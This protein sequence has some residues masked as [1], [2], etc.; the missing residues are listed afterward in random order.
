[1]QNVA[2]NDSFSKIFSKELAI[3]HDTEGLP[4]NVK[5]QTINYYKRSKLLEIKMKSDKLI[6]AQ[7]LADIEDR[8]AGYFNIDSVEVKV[9]YIISESIEALLNS[10]W[11]SIVFS[12]CR[13]LATS[14]GL[15]SGCKWS[16]SERKLT[17]YLKTKGADI[18]KAQG[19]AKH[20]ET[21]IEEAFSTRIK[22]EFIDCI[23]DEN[24]KKKY[25]EKKKTEEQKVLNNIIIMSADNKSNSI[26]KN[27]TGSNQASVADKNETQSSIIFGKDFNDSLLKMKEINQDSGKVSIG[28]D[29][30]KVEFRE[31]RGE[32]FICTFDITDNTNSLTVKFFVKKD[33]I[34]GVKNRIKEG[35]TVKVRGEAQ[36]DKFSRDVA[37]MASDIVLMGKKQKRMDTAKVKRVE[38]HLHTQMSAMDGVTSVEALVKRASEWGHKAIAI[39]DHGVIQA[40]PGASAMAGKSNIKIIYGVECYLVDDTADEN[41]DY[42]K[43]HAYH[44]II[45][46]Q[47]NKGLKNLYKLI[48]K[49]HL[50][51]YYKKPRMFKSMIL[52]YRE[53]LILGTA[54]E[55]GELYNAV[56]DNKSEEE[57]NRIVSFYDYLEIQPLG[58]NQFLVENGRVKNR[59][60]L[61]KINMEIVKLGEKLQKPVVAT[62]DV[63]FLD[64]EDEVY[65]R[66]LMA[67]QGY[68]DADK[69]APLYLRT[70]DEMLAE[71]EYLG[72]EKAYE[73]V[74]SNPNKINDMLETIAPVP[75]GTFP[76]QIEGA[77]YEIKEL[78]INH[79]KEK[80]GDPLPEIVEDRLEKEL[81]SIIKN[82]FSVMYLIAIKLVRKSLSDGYLVGSRGSVGSSF[83]AYLTGITEVNPLHAHYVCNKCKYSE[84][85]TDG[86]IDCGYDL[87]GKSCPQCGENL[88]RDG[89][90]I[91]FETFLGFNGDKEPDIDLNFS[92]Q[93][94]PTA[95]KFVE[96]LFGEGHVFRAGTIAS[97]AE[98]TAYGFAK[99][100]LDE[101]GIVT[102]TAELNRLIK[103][104]TGI[105]RTTGQHPGGVM[106]IPQD[107]EIYDFTPIQHPAD[108]TGSNTITTHFDYNFLHGSILKLD[109]LGHDDP[110]TIRMLEDLTGIDARTIPIGDPETMKLFSSTSSLGVTP[111]DVN[112]EV[113]TLGIPEF[114]TRFV[115]QMLV[116]TRPKTMSELIRISGLSHGTDVWINNAQDLIKANIASLSEVIC[117]RDD[118]MLYLLY[119]GLP[120]ITSFKIMED[121]RKGKGLKPEYEDIMKANNVPAWYIDSCKKI[122]YMFPKAHAAAYVMMAFRIAWFKVNYPV[123]FYTTYFTVKADEFDAEV[124]TQNHDIIK[125]KIMELED[126]GN[127]VTQK[128]KS[129]LTLLEVVNEMYSR[130]INF[131]PV[132]LYK[133]EAK[134]FTIDG[135]SIRPPLNGLPGLGITAAQNIVEARKEEKFSSIE[136]LRI[137]AKVSKTVIDILKQHGCLDDLPESSQISLF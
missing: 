35:I 96:E 43:A 57:I 5:V 105:K 117:T 98:K 53:G 130:G 58:N 97:V 107:K 47:N 106:I 9:K 103:G 113:G 65:R 80:Y 79:A 1:V 125:E 115:R 124:M 133:S 92:G 2:L 81:E 86:S 89:Y 20:M 67:G 37:I 132:D 74:I 45:L 75:K 127:N 111:E 91:P 78:S 52:Q 123:E 39:T 73:V 14:R 114:G 7:V 16:L 15:L 59:E 128:D 46:V 50:E 4:G 63:H 68:S 90:D 40:Y 93:Y 6:P 31:I 126:K 70:T 118:I 56:L 101:R 19:C 3:G 94:Q 134:K 84:F 25:I 119:A 131:I 21:L 34:D 18:L 42:T 66:I 27:A 76:P 28:G 71:F 12:T 135:G 61:K 116:E 8:F 55:A 85:I 82:G 30:L 62:C 112:S 54:C 72:E 29:I 38:L 99:N 104:C 32:R 122:K 136:D 121:V 22:V 26:Y 24:Y 137:R 64:P 41:C 110:T 44:A 17:V 83:V 60:E 77:E 102:T 108:D 36:Y 109:I 23:I 100:Y 51:Y 88:K 10:Y 49:S 95:H 129:I 87:S 69:Q 11:E 120:P 13:K 48:S 33:K